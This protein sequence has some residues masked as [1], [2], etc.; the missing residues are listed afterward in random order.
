MAYSKLTEGLFA[1]SDASG[2]IAL[3]DTKRIGEEVV[4]VDAQDGPP[5]MIVILFCFFNFQF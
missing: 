5:E 2:K 4:N 3:W 1:S